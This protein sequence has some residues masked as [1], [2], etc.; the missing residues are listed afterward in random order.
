MG[1]YLVV[2]CA[3]AFNILNENCN[4]SMLFG[5]LESIRE[6]VENNLLESLEVNFYFVRE[7]TFEGQL[8]F[9]LLSFGLV[10][11]DSGDTF[12]SRFY[13]MRTYVLGELASFELRQC[14]NV[15]NVEAD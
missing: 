13:V 14:K 9:H 8:D 3:S 15:F 11:E 4:P 7:E 5:E 10:P 12:D 2:R 1:L 6:I